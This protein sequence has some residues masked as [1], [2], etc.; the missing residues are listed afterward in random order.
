LRTKI[1]LS[2]PPF[3][4]A[5]TGFCPLFLYSGILRCASCRFWRIIAKR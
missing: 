2:T 1:K 3:R 4:I 5:R